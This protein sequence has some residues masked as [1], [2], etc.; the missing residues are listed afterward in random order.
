LHNALDVHRRH[1][2]PWENVKIEIVNENQVR[3]K[4]G[5]TRVFIPMNEKVFNFF[6]NLGKWFLHFSEP[7]LLGKTI[8]PKT[9][10]N[11][12][13]RNTAVIYRRGVRVR[14]I[15]H[16]PQS[17]FDYNLEKLNLDESRNV[18]EWMVQAE[19]ACAIAFSGRENL[20]ILMQSFLGESVFWEHGFQENALFPFSANSSAIAVAKSEWRSAFENVFG[21]NAVVATKNGGEMASRKGY[22]VVEIPEGMYLASSKFDIPTPNK[23]L[24][25]DDLEGRELTPATRHVIDAVNWI[26]SIA[27]QHMMLNGKSKPDVECFTKIMTNGCQTL[28]FYRQ[29]KVFV[30]TD[31]AGGMTQQLLVTVAEEV[32]HHVTG[33]TD[34]SR[35]FQDYLLNL[36]VKIALQNKP[37]SESSESVSE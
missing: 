33:A 35:D 12:N 17:L 26:W 20:S 11:L 9:N 18:N 10:R 36:M 34:N 23:V 19:A 25:I 15:A 14:E 8:L 31:I 2:K 5:F 29:N 3:A 16:G 1:A 4:A 28:G 6:N 37:L 21:A 13:E 7:E 22:T 32:T 30:N 24:S 27:E